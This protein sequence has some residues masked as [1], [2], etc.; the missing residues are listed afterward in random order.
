MKKIGRT[1]KPFSVEESIAVVFVMMK[2]IVV[3]LANASLLLP[4]M[5]CRDYG[6]A[7]VAA[8]ILP[9]ACLLLI[10]GDQKEQSNK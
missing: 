7:Y 5:S 4:F 9:P 8:R 3:Q 1:D 6:R 2:S 10:E